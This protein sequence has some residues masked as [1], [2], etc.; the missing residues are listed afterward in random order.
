MFLPRVGCVLFLLSV[1][2][3][4]LSTQQLLLGSAATLN[5]K[6]Q[7][8]RST[9]PESRSISLVSLPTSVKKHIFDF[10]LHHDEVDEKIKE[11]ARKKRGE[12]IANGG[13][14]KPIANGALCSSS[15]NLAGAQ[16]LIAKHRLRQQQPLW[17][18]EELLPW[19]AHLTELGKTLALPRAKNLAPQ[20]HTPTQEDVKREEK[21]L[22]AL[23]EIADTPKAVLRWW[24]LGTDVLRDGLLRKV[25]FLLRN[26]RMVRV[27]GTSQ[28]SYFPGRNG[29]GGRPY[30]D[31]LFNH[32]AIPFLPQQKGR[33]AAARA[34][35]ALA[36]GL[37]AAGQLMS[38]FLR[39]VFETTKWELVPEP[40]DVDRWSSEE[41]VRRCRNCPPKFLALKDDEWFTNVFL[42]LAKEWGSEFLANMRVGGSCTQELFAWQAQEWR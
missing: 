36:L 15:H 42:P 9:M 40:V 3:L 35:I 18:K 2:S 27:R 31:L 33:A 12:S 17:R 24:L 11:E 16:E 10:F 4:L 25:P 32:N 13:A 38:G 37:H 19:S 39:S 30:R 22:D 41:E 26:K 20:P 14:Q 21:Q 28:S 34:K 5:G 1:S 23:V 6:P 8:D 29:G 7:D